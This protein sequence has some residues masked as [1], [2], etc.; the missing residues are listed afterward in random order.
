MLRFWI[1]KLKF[2]CIFASSGH[3]ALAREE[4]K[5]TKKDL[6]DAKSRADEINRRAAEQL[7]WAIDQGW[8]DE[9]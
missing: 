2:M 8:N 5:L 1:Q 7:L 6:D 4:W 9:D 3:W